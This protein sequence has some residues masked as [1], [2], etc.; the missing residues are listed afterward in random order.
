M[1]GPGLE[2]NRVDVLAADKMEN[3]QSTEG[4]LV[5]CPRC[6]SSASWRYGRRGATQEYLCRGCGRKFNNRG[7]P[8]GMRTP[9]DQLGAAL[10]MFYE[11]LSLVEISRELG[12]SY[13]NPVNPSSVHRW[14]IK[15]T[16]QAMES[17][18]GLQVQ[19]SNTWVVDETVEKVGGQ[20]VWF[21]DVIDYNSLFLLA[22]R[23]SRIRTVPDVETVLERAFEKSG[24]APK[25]I[26]FN[27]LVADSASIAQ[28]FGTDCQHIQSQGL[29]SK[30]NSSLIGQLRGSLKQRTRVMQS[31]KSLE[32]AAL[33]LSG[34]LIHYNFFRPNKT[35]K[36]KT[37]AAVVGLNT[38]FKSWLDIV[39]DSGGAAGRNYV[40]PFTLGFR[41]ST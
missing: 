8:L 15:Y 7:S 39:I 40:E 6:L 16:K 36:D 41:R 30:G 21:W 19:A 22:S 11:G 35:L 23:L 33:A 28:V 24:T 27:G 31:L 17:L 2:N 5:L 18:A 14:V 37:P 32:K 20:D 1:Q 25:S 9:T 29:T 3:I 12:R 13:S 26:L 38:Q 34:F 4:Q 10:S